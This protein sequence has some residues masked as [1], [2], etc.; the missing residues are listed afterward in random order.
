MRPAAVQ[1]LLACRQFFHIVLWSS[2][3]LKNLNAGL[4]S[5]FPTVRELFRAVLAQ[6][7]CRTAGFTLSD[8]NGV[9]VDRE[10]GRKPIFLKCLEDIWCNELVEFTEENTLLVD[11]T[12]YKSMLNPYH[13]CICPPSF[14]PEDAEQAPMFLLETLLPWLMRWRVS[15]TPRDFVHL[16]MM[17]NDKDTLSTAVMEHQAAC[18][19]WM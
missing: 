9:L 10:S 1:F 16:N 18:D 14:D 13:C 15:K 3:T 19:K 11:D 4:M 7:R 17:F 2:C 5:C 6:D 12:R 8:V